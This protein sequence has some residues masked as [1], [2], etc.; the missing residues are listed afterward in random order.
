LRKTCWG[1]SSS[2]IAAPLAGISALPPRAFL[3]G[4]A[5]S[6]SSSWRARRRVR[7]AG[8]QARWRHE[9]AARRRP[10]LWP[11]PRRVCP[12]ARHRLLNVIYGIAPRG[13]LAHCHGRRSVRGHRNLAVDTIPAGRRNDRYGALRGS[14]AAP[15]E[16]SLRS[17]A[18]HKCSYY[19]E[20]SSAIGN[21]DPAGEGIQPAAPQPVGAPEPDGG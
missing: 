1:C 20:R 3:A 14:L 11:N 7:R 21:S 13:I 18:W 4:I 5:V 17:H 19:P 6:A 8:R 16:P 2:A 10:R 9:L 15:L 12:A